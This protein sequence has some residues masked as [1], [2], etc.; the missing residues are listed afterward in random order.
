MAIDISV[1]EQETFFAPQDVIVIGSGMVGLWS[2]FF[3][4]KTHPKLKITIV[5]SGMIPTGA[6]TRNAGFACFGSLSELV[7]DAQIMGTDKMLELVE[8]RYKGLE[9][10][11]KYFSKK[12]IDFKL[13]GGYELYEEN[14]ISTE[15]LNENIDYLNSLLKP[16]TD[17][18]KTYRLAD[19]KTAQ[20]GFGNTKHLVKN[21]LE[22]YLHPGK[23]VQALLHKVQGMGVS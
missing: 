5:D 12:E 9:R 11:E 19:E 16:I 14:K 20:F 3:L 15:K 13:C 1:W 22:G 17:T 6:S 23:L 4:K 10:I 21:K 2:A 7:E 8:M 18:K